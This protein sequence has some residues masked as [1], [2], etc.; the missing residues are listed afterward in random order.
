MN[1]APDVMPDPLA[2]YAARLGLP[3]ASGAAP[4]DA[5]EQLHQDLLRREEGREAS[6]D[7]VVEASI[8]ARAALALGPLRQ[9]LAVDVKGR[10]R[11][12][13]TPP[14]ARA[15]MSP[16][17]WS[18]NP[19]TRGL[20]RLRERWFGR[21]GRLIAGSDEVH[22]DSPD[23]RGRWRGAATTRR[24]IL[25]A[26]V[27]AQTWLASYFM[28][29]ILP[30]H[31]Q[32]PLEAV[33]MVLYAVL[34]AWV[35]AGFWTALMGFWALI[36][37]GDRYAIS[38]SAPADAPIDPA[39]RTGLIMPIC[40]EDVAR[41]FAGLRATYDSL[42]R[43]GAREH[44]DLFILSDT[45]D[46]DTRVAELEAWRDLCRQVHGFGHIHYRRRTN[47]IKRKSGN[48]ADW[49]R[50]WGSRFKYFIVL[51]ADSVMSGACLKRL[52]QL[53][54]ANPNAG[55][56]QTAPIAAGRETLYSRIQQFATRV[57]G[58]LFTAGLHFWQLGESH[59]WGHNAIIRT[60]PF[61]RH[62]ALGRL[63]GRGALAG[64]I[65]SHDFVEAALM[66]RAGWAVWIAYDLPGSYEE[67]PPNLLDELKRD[68]RWCQ[69][70]LQNFKLFTAQ[71]LH[72]AHRAVFMTGVMAYLSAPLWFL[73]LALSTALLALH[74]LSEPTYFS[75]PNQLFPTWPE[76]RP[77]W[78]LRL[79]GGTMTLLFLPKVLAVLLQL[80][81]PQQ[82]RG[83]GGPLRL[84]ASLALEVLF[85]ALLAPVRML[86]HTRFVVSALLGIAI[87]WKSPPR[88]D[89]ATPWGEALRHHGGGTLLGCLWLGGV[90]WLEPAFLA[91]LL[92]VAG[93]LILAVPLSVLSSRVG[94]G[95]WCRERRLFLIPEESLAPRELR[96]LRLA[97]RRTRRAYSGFT[98]AVVDPLVNG[99]V[100]AQGLIRERLPAAT[101]GE[102]LRLAEL[103]FS[104]GPQALSPAE[105]NTLL[106]D[107]RA[108]SGL[109]Q[110]VWTVAGAHADWQAPRAAVQG[111]AACTSRN[112]VQTLRL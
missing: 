76:W 54:E 52:V 90:Y 67:M 45:S 24:L 30:H 84:L 33:L 39:A 112:P 70:N 107:P 85:S 31:G 56:I 13:T 20:Q 104:A 108:L 82:L 102:R 3:A 46:P 47:R 110:R 73:F 59:Y 4:S 64:E 49:C 38:R 36:W 93:S 61:M 35:G 25:V 11:L 53:M 34:F 100:A 12:V 81:R 92:P 78:A 79:F 48:V 87:Q 71:G 9:A 88:E 94:L 15:H 86:F 58:P 80:L 105:R 18:T 57:Y 68:R 37:G 32:H 83:F 96:W 8:A 41:V 103:A 74:V 2:G 63:P 77:E 44:F 17:P 109:H 60:A 5:F 22:P 10:N 7:P 97:L 75:Q 98:E 95:R 6:A 42:A 69:G 65:L 16:R 72:P 29:A 55:I 51:D 50:R 40:N 91:W 66:R 89:S 106:S 101:R 21:R 28:T 62:C 27:L 14:L 43:A 19:L 26:L 111:E 1:A 99:L 23:P